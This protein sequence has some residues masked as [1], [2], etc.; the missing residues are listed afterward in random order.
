[1]VIIPTKTNM[2]SV[3]GLWIRVLKPQVWVYGCHYSVFLDLE[4]ERVKLGSY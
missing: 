2:L 1:M 4:G 3:I